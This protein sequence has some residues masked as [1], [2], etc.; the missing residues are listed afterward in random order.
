MRY[1]R[2]QVMCSERYEKIDFPIPTFIPCFDDFFNIIAGLQICFRFLF[3]FRNFFSLLDG[4]SPEFPC[5]LAKNK[6]VRC[7]Q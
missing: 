5:P 2:D 3:P 7:G 1:S 4:S 6:F